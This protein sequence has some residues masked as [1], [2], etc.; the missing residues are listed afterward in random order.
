VCIL[1][2]VQVEM[3]SKILFGSSVALALVVAML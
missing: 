2:G 1:R 3:S